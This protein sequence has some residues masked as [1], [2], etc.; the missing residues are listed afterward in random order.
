M[1]IKVLE[2]NMAKTRKA[3]LKRF[4][5]TKKGKIL[6][7]ISGQSHNFIKKESKQLLRKKKLIQDDDLVLEY[8]NY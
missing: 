8:K 7:L 6:R 2:K 1:A 3:F 4:K 5:I